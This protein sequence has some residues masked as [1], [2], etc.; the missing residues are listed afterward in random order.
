MT[1][2]SRDVVYD[3]VIQL[4]CWYKTAAAGVENDTPESWTWHRDY[5]VKRYMMSR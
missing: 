4:T 5:S 3:N 2:Q 1:R